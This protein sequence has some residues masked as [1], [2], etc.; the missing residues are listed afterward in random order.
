MQS[1]AACNSQRDSG[2]SRS[3][4]DSAGTRTSDATLLMLPPSST[5]STSAKR[6]VLE[7]SCILNPTSIA[8]DGARALDTVACS[9]WNMPGPVERVEQP[10]APGSHHHT[11]CWSSG[12][13]AIHKAWETTPTSAG[14]AVTMYSVSVCAVRGS[15]ARP[16][17]STAP[18]EQRRQQL[19]VTPTGMPY[20][21][22]TTTRERLHSARPARVWS[23]LFG[24][25]AIKPSSPSS[26]RP[27]AGNASHCS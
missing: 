14:V 11:R 19:R 2:T 5:S 24:S 7:C 20:R 4:R 22:E 13:T 16:A 17:T 15:P 9:A 23:C 26:V 27:P 8:A 18:T 1:G 21:L 10:D 25:M 3:L 12:F 6:D